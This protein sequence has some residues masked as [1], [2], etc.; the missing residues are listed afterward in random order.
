MGG[1]RLFETVIAGT[2]R[3]GSE[4]F[5]VLPPNAYTTGG[6]SRAKRYFGIPV[7]VLVKNKRLKIMNF[8][9]DEFGVFF[10]L[11]DLQNH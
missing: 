1:C 8:P 11:K 4:N 10:Q 9:Q 6:K 3:R 5:E 7:Q 2:E